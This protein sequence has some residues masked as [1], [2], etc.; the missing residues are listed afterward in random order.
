M[1]QGGRNNFFT[2]AFGTLLKANVSPECCISI[3]QDWNQR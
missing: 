1:S 3:C 2:K